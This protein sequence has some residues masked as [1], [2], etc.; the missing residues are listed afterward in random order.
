M[1]RAI[2]LSIVLMFAAVAMN[3]QTAGIAGAHMG[4]A[5]G[6]SVRLLVS[7]VGAAGL[8]FQV[9]G[10]ICGATLPGGRLSRLFSLLRTCAG[11][12]H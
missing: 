5:R 6:Q 7:D 12:A 11:S 8:R 4:M 9:M 1:R 10:S 3:S 2:T